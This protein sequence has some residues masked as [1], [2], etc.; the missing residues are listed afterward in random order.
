[1]V[2]A[3][4][5]AWGQELAAERAMVSVV[6]M[7]SGWAEKMVALMVAAL[8][9]VLVCKWDRELVAKWATHSVQHLGE[10]LDCLME[11]M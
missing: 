8:V 11:V 5:C 9:S 3:W 7:E 10:K 6:K 1:M 4:E 2:L